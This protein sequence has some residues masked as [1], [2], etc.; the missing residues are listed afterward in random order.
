MG[1]IFL[2]G[3]VKTKALIQTGVIQWAKPAMCNKD[4]K[5][6][7]MFPFNIKWTDLVKN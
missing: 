7:M 2:T 4:R 5:W 1:L 6:L 3:Q